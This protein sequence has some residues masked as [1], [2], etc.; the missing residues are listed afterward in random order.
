MSDSKLIDA[1]GGTNKVAEI[2]MLSASAVSCWRK[3]GIP[4]P[5][6]MHLKQLMPKRKPMRAK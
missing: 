6:R 4:R 1:L 2:C 3:R 5:W